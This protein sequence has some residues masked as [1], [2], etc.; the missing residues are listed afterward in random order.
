MSSKFK[1]I[2]QEIG[3]VIGILAIIYGVYLI[4]NALK[5]F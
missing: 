1:K 4:L 2:M 3:V 5:I